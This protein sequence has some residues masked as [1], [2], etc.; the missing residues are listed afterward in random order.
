[1]LFAASPLQSATEKRD[2]G[3]LD[4]IASALWRSLMERLQTPPAKASL[5]HA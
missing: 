2:E 3:I 5:G 4:A 1:V